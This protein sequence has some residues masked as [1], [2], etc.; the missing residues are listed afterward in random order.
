[1]KKI[2]ASLILLGLMMCQTAAYAQVSAPIPSKQ[3]ALTTTVKTI[4][5]TKGTLQW[6]QCYNPSNATAYIQ[7]FDVVGTVT[8]G[9]T[10]PKLSLPIATLTNMPITGPAQF[11]SAIKVAATTTAGGL[12]APSTA[13]DCNFGFN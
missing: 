3:S 8:L 7:V 10:V 1:M 11:F 4:K 2:L 6:G 12:T 9:T 13:L 5:A